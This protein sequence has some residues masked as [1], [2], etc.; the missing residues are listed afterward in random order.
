MV[1]FTET[2][3]SR[4]YQSPEWRLIHIH[5]RIVTK[6]SW[7]RPVHK[8]KEVVQILSEL[9]EMYGRDNCLV[10]S[11]YRKLDKKKYEVVFEVWQHTWE[12]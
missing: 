6:L 11:S 7:F 12:G 4:R 10:T 5:S 1:E 2:G 8:S 3:M 9:I